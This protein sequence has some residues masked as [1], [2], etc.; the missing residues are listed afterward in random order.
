LLLITA[1]EVKPR[2]IRELV[3]KSFPLEAKQVGVSLYSEKQFVSAYEAGGLFFMH[4][5]KEGRI[6]YDD[7]FYRQLRKK[8]FELSNH[9]MKV[10]LR[11]QRQ[12]LELLDDLQKFNRIFVGTLASLFSISKNLVF[13]LLAL[14]GQYIFNKRRAFSMLAKKHP[15]FKE[16]IRKLYGLEPFFLRNTEGISMS[17]PFCPYNCEEKV[18]E[19]KEAVRR[20]MD[21]IAKND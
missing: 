4:L 16:E 20:I 15:N 13:T 7:G 2:K 18:I 1:N 10:A 6:L 17:L 9:K 21:G 14:D 8:P 11:I 3:R 12:K 19:M 5:L